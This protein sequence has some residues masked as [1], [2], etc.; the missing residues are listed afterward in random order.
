[1][2]LHSSE[3]QQNGISHVRE[4]KLFWLTELKQPSKC[5]N[6]IATW[7]E[8]SRSKSIALS[9]KIVMQAQGNQYTV[10]SWCFM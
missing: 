4:G 3:C 8:S 2:T 6:L 7:Y 9:C 10:A 1:M 5:K